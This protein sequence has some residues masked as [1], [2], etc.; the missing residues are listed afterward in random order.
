MVRVRVRL[1]SLLRDAVGKPVVEVDVEGEPTLG[2]VVKRLYE[3]YPRLRE[4]V[5]GLEKRGLEVVYMVNG[6]F[7]GFDEKVGESDEVVVLP[8][9]SG[10]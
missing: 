10:G 8:P 2:E 9:A 6:R 1:V 7:A 4:V 5:E 3:I